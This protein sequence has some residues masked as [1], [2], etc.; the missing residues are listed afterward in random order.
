ML[1]RKTL[2]HDGQ[3]LIL[4]VTFNRS[5]AR[6]VVASALQDGAPFGYSIAAGFEPA[7]Y[8]E[9]FASAVAIVQASAATRNVSRSRP[10]RTEL[11]HLRALQVLDALHAGASQREIALALFGGE[12]VARYW[13]PDGDLRAQVRYLIRRGR[14]HMRG[15]YR[16]LMLVDA[17]TD[18]RKRLTTI[19]P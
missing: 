18:R 7:D 9:P 6:L 16:K 11:I 12:R 2:W 14:E 8:G 1:G 5:S 19:S 13:E 10:T 15:G 4:D 17:G 3:K